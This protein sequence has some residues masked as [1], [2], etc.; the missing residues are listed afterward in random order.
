MTRIHADAISGMKAQYDEAA[1]R[2]LAQ[3]SL[4]ALILKHT[5]EEFMEMTEEDIEACIE[6][7]PEIAP[8]SVDPDSE[9]K[10]EITGESTEST[11]PGEGKI[12]Y[13]IRFAAYKPGEKQKIKLIINIEA[14]KKW[15]PGYEL[16]TRGIFYCARMISEQKHKEFEKS[17]Y[18]RIKKVYSIWICMNGPAGMESGIASY[19]FTKRDYLGM[20]P[21]KHWAYDKMEVVLVA[22]NQSGETENQLM[23]VLRILFSENADA[24]KKEAML[25]EHGVHVDSERNKEVETMCNLS[26]LIEERATERG[27]KK[28]IEKGIE[29]GK[30]QTIL[31]LIQAG[32]LT[33]EEGARW[34]NKTEEEMEELCREEYSE[35]R[36]D[37]HA[38]TVLNQSE[39]K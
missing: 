10:T 24:Q 35:Y 12:T 15:N 2:L 7:N 19:R 29:K 4:L 6:G 36:T 28:G 39:Q 34:L 18:D 14:Q 1:K 3:K 26:D 25:R 11:I 33:A 9:Q 13:D 17:D 22:L 21:D 20:L 23:N 27:M 30:C 32:V 8:A 37:N 38:E 5:A 16:V 31:E